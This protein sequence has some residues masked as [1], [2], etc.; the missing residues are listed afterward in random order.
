[1]DYWT[2]TWTY[3]CNVR[4]DTSPKLLQNSANTATFHLSTKN[5]ELHDVKTRKTSLETA[6]LNSIVSSSNRDLQIWWS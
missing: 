2:V 5:A 6:H 1:M 4:N 3:S